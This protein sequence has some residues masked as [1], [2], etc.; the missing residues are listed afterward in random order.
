VKELVRSTAPL[1]LTLCAAALAGALVIS[2]VR[3]RCSIE[4]KEL[5]GLLVQAGKLQ[6]GIEELKV[7]VAGL[8]APKRLERA[9]RKIGMVYP[10]HEQFL[11]RG[12][13]KAR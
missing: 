5:R 2:G 9:A 4:Q 8:L 7:E 6:D 10:R 1:A 3:S 11:T 13:E 12:A